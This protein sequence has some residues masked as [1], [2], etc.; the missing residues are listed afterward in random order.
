MQTISLNLWFD[1]E[2]GE[3]AQF[4]TSAFENAKVLES[5]FY[6]EAGFEIHKM[7]AGTVLT[8]EFEIEGQKFMALNG[9]PLF[10]FTPAISLLVRCSNRGEVDALWDRLS[11]GGTALMPLDAY[12]FSERYGW[13]QDRYGLSWQVMLVGDRREQKI[14]PMLMFVGEQCG[15]AEEAMRLYASVF[16]NSQVGDVVRYGKDEGPDREGTIKYA[17]FTLDGQEFAAMDSGYP[18]NFGFNEAVSLVVECT[19]QEEID[20][21]WEKLS[22]GGDPEA[23]QCGWLKDRFGVSWQ[24]VP[25]V[26][27]G[28]L[29][30]QDRKKVERVTNAFLKMKKF[31]I[32]ALEQAYRG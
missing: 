18:H 8:R 23:Q 14:V 2:A 13:V 5:M 12:P 25:T 1:K 31:D 20:Y 29:R 10:K 11:S 21:Y 15:R 28:M 7:K 27:G 3:A 17:G 4:Y 19:T 26:L 24:V 30:D 16:Q 6:T 9:G 32:A 22:E